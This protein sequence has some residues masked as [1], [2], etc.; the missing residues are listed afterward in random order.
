MRLYAFHS[1]GDYSDKCINDPLD[2]NVGEK[3]YIPWFCYLITHPKGNVLFD[4]GVDPAMVSGNL[5]EQFGDWADALDFQFNPGDDVVSKLASVGLKPADIDIVVMSHLHFDHAVG[6][7][8]FAHARIL[9]QRAELAFAHYPPVYQAG[10]YFA[11][12]FTGNYKWELLDGPHDI[13]GDGRLEIFPTPGHTP[14]SQSLL[15][16]GDESRV[17]LLGD[18]A[19]SLPKMRVRRLPGFL[20]S[21]DQMV[22][23]WQFI[24]WMEKKENA[25]LLIMHDADFKTRVR[26]GPDAFYS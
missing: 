10:T 12:Y 6:L 14:G 16:R 5:R 15:F 23:S 3:I 20:W 2:L 18:A 26:L 24:E 22:A 11:K 21:P 8:L 17:M 13:F 25:D 4:S 1:G 7:P 9:V 19:Y